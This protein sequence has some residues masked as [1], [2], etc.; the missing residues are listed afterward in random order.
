MQIKEIVKWNVRV[1]M[2]Y[3]FGI[4]TLL[5]T[6]G[7]YQYMGRNEEKPVKEEKEEEPPNP[8]EVT[9]QSAHMKTTIIYKENFVPYST[10]IYNFVSSLS[11]DSASADSQDNTK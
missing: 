3:A 8:R 2:L 1:S 5:G 11:G 6:Y 7:Y 4:W 10:R 9:I